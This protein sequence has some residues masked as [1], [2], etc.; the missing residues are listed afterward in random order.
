MKKRILSCLLVLVMAMSLLP[1]NVFAA[2]DTDD[3]GSEPS[4]TP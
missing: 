2:L 1:V 3:S 4:A